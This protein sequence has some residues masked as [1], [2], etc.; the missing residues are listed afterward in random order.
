MEAIYFF[1]KKQNEVGIP[2]LK[3]SLPKIV[4]H[5]SCHIGA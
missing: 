1:Q 5:I 2:F 4:V 3:A